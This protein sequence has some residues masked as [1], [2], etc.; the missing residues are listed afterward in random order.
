MKSEV[1]QSIENKQP[2][3]KISNKLKQMNLDK[4]SNLK[5]NSKFYKLQKNKRSARI[6]LKSINGESVGQINYRNF[7]NNIYNDY[8]EENKNS[9]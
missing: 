5:S 3:S 1:S 6:K 2:D 7:G 9:T 8:V 4:S